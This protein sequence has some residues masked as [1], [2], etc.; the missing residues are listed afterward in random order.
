MWW[1]AS[2]IPAFRRLMDEHHRVRGSLV[3]IQAQTSEQYEKEF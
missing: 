1:H 3:H 2:L